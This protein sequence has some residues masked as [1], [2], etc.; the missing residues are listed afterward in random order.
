MK[1][2]SF[3]SSSSTFISSCLLFV[4]GVDVVIDERSGDDD[5]PF[6]CAVVALFAIDEFV[7]V[8]VVDFFAAAAACCCCFFF[9]DEDIDC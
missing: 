1:N 5:S 8:V 2:A 7:F 3:D 9:L 4:A 6:R